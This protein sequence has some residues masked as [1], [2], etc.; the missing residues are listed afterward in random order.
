MERCHRGSYRQLGLQYGNKSQEKLP[1]ICI[2]K[3]K[4]ARNARYAHRLTLLCSKHA[5]FSCD[6]IQSSSLPDM[7]AT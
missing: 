2:Y 3:A 1:L 6:E 4:P 5:S 7:L